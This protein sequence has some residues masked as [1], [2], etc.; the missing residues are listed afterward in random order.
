MG[1]TCNNKIAYSG[2]QGEIENSFWKTLK[3][4]PLEYFIGE[5]LAEDKIRETYKA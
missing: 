2:C 5:K 4:K 1:F 3:Q